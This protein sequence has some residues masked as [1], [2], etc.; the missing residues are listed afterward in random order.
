MPHNSC[1][2][3]RQ[4]VEDQHGSEEGIDRRRGREVSD[5]LGEGQARGGVELGLIPL[6]RRLG[7]VEEERDAFARTLPNLPHAS[8]PV[9]TSEADNVEIRR[10]GEPPRFD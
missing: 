5:R 2:R 3:R 4:D 8:V 1:Y 10:V 6:A 9:G 7:A